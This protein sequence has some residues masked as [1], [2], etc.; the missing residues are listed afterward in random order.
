MGETG[1]DGRS[2]VD[3]GDAQEGN[4]TVDHGTPTSRPLMQP[5]ELQSFSP[6]PP[7]LAVRGSVVRCG[8]EL[9]LRYRLIDPTGLLLV[10]PAA[11]APQRRDGLWEHTCL[12]AFLAEPGTAPY[13]ELNLAPSG[14]WNLYRLSGYRQGLTS[15]SAISA[16]PLALSRRPDGLD[17]AVSL[18]LG[19]LPLAG[20]PLELGITAVLELSDGGILYWALRHPG[21]EA[22]FHLREGFGLRV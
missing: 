16:L 6:P 3:S 20:R 2:R 11:A 5:F 12:E 21:A 17:L 4:R 15:E 7:G 10:P 14:D 1:R 8:N 9:S 18:D 19:V 22:D 13:W